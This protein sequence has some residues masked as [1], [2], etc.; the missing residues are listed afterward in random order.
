MS[1]EKRRDNAHSL[2]GRLG[3]NHGDFPRGGHNPDKSKREHFAAGG[4]VHADAK[5]D[6]KLI[7][8]DVHKHEKHLHKGEPE[9]KLARGG[10]AHG[11]KKGKGAPHVTVVVGQ[12]PPP[13]PMPAPV[14]APGPVGGS[15][16]MAAP[17][18]PPHPPM[19][20]PPP[21]MPPGGGMGG[22]GAPP[23]A[24]MRKRGGRTRG[25]ADCG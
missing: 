5:Q 11:G 6:E 18:M 13:A 3:Y 24:M 4:K 12:H 23:M 8:K 25:G 2:M 10:A 14:K 1:T 17:P 21:G 16:P 7:A 22:P 9:T 20:A 19:G 15:P